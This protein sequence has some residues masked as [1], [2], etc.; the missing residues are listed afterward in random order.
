MSFRGAPAYRVKPMA[1]EMA[2]QNTTATLVLEP[3]GFD[4][5]IVD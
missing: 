2:V 1:M 3:Y 5:L 4:V